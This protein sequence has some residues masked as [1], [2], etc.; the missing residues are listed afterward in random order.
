MMTLDEIL[1]ADAAPVVAILRGLRPD[2]ALDI[3]AA[4]VEAG[5]RLIEVP[6]NSPAP[7]DS[8]ASLQQTFGADALIGAGTV[9]DVAAVDAVAATGARLIVTPN[10]DPAVIARSVALGLE[11]MPGFL[12]PTE[13]F[14]AYKAGARRLKL[15][16]AGELG[17]GYIKAVRAVLPADA[18]L[19]AI[20]GADA[21]SVGEWLAAGC[22]GIGVG[23]ALFKP[24]DTAAQ[25]SAKAKTLVAATLAALTKLADAG[26]RGV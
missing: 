4:L 19:W 13:A 6:M 14:S 9:L 21:G 2:E 23:S 26:A 17:V 8:I 3:G 12:S 1:N 15:F 16:P 11:P 24:G 20:G 25:V 10:T 18:R 22:E 5:V 7:L